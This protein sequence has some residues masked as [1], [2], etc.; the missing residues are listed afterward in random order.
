MRSG[1]SDCPEHRPLARRHGSDRER[2]RSRNQ[3]YAIVSRMNATLL[4]A[5]VAL[6]PRGAFYS[7]G[8]IVTFFRG[9]TTGSLLQ[10]LGATFL[11]VVVVA[12]ICEA[13]QLFSQMHW[14]NEHSAGHYLDLSSAVLGATL[15]PIGYLRSM[16]SKYEAISLQAR[17]H[18]PRADKVGFAN[19]KGGRPSERYCNPLPRRTDVPRV[20]EPEPSNSRIHRCLC[21]LGKEAARCSRRHSTNER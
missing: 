19:D 6:V 5:L 3:S 18:S 8:A 12:H 14:G 2:S 10:L 7:L 16:R 15:F 20:D 21:C 11:V 17:E 13:L 9:R 4:K 1:T